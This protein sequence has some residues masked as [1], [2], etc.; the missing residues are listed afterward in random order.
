MDRP[1]SGR[2]LSRRTVLK[3][4]AGA[5]AVAAFS[6]L[7]GRGRARA[8][9]SGTVRLTGWSASPQERPLLEQALEGFRA[10]FPN[11]DL[12]YEPIPGNYL[13]VLQTQLAAGEVADVFYVDAQYAQDLAS[14]EVLL[15]LD[16]YMGRAGVT[17]DQFYPSLISA[18][19]WQGQTF[20]L[21]KDWSSIAMVYSQDA[22]E[23]AGVT[24]PPT[25]WE[26]LRAAAQTLADNGVPTP[27]ILAPAFDKFFPFFVQAGATV[28][29][30]EVT[31]FTINSEQ[32][33]QA[34]EY[35]QGLYNDQL[36]ATFQDFG[37]QDPQTA[38]AQGQGALFLDGNWVYA[39]LQET[40]PDLRF[41]AAEPPA[42]PAGKGTA[43]FTVSYSISRSSEN[44]DAAW[45][46]VNYLCGD[47][48]MEV[49]TGGGFA[50]PSRPSLAEQWTQKF[51][52]RAS[53]L[54]ALDYARVAQFGPGG[55]QFRTDADTVIS[56]LLAGSLTPDEA[57]TRLE[58]AATGA[59]Q[60]A[61]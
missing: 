30:P 10:K 8:Q 2:G 31:Q 50:M 32:T 28:T 17:P 20:G 58:E 45:E 44:P 54:A 19:Q 3:G 18:F 1:V 60:L 59:I 12:Q 51:P 23:Q 13:E 35:Y 5:T 37:A 27:I 56:E 14:R 61:S 6:P 22:L 7:M 48:G 53:F 11:I 9:A 34:L 24:A 41:A 55:Q 40:A 38:F 26:E 36:G 33:R 52:E 42:G 15:P 46:L 49:W 25:N 43:G 29:N 39:P 4:A 21:P 47:E 57:V 16:D